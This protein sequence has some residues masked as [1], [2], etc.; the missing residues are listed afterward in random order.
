[1]TEIFLHGKKR[2]WTNKNTPQIPL[3]VIIN[4]NIKIKENISKK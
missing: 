4:K 2:L 3:G 1:M